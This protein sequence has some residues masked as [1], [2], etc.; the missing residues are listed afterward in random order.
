[1]RI[2]PFKT[3]RLIL[4][5]LSMYP[6]D[7]TARKWKKIAHIITTL[8]ILIITFCMI[9]SS[10]AFFV[11]FVSVDLEEALYS[12]GQIIGYS[13]VLYMFIVGIFLRHKINAIILRLTDIYKKCE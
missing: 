10:V 13:M 11:R 12:L 3:N 6:A 4:T 9:S 2:K 8:I 7:E 5:W 1:M